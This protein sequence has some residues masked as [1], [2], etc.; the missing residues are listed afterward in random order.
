MPRAPLRFAVALALG[1]C[2]PLERLPYTPATTPEQWCRIRPCVEI[3]GII[4]NEPLGSL[5]VYLLT[6]MLLLAGRYV[7]RRRAR[8]NSRRWWAWALVL[9]GV[10]A[11]LAGTSYQAFSYELKC[12]GREVC[13]WTSWWEVAYL[14]IQNASIDCMVIAVAY[15]CTTGGLRTLLIGYAGANAAIHMMVTVYGAATANA[16]LI[17]FELLLLFSLPALLTGVGVNGIRF[18]RNRTAVDRVLLG[19]WA[20]LVATNGAYFAY[21]LA[22]CTQRLWKGGAGFYFSEN[23]VLHLG[24]IGWTLYVVR[25]VARRIAD[26]DERRGST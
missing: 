16:F 14:T 2:G 7:W 15:S 20:W 23:D 21:A 17:S 10:A 18:L 19:A 12:A 6:G 26:L 24:M 11:G 9:G 8:E 22:G 4:V 5:L 25:V 13:L 1:G 3:G